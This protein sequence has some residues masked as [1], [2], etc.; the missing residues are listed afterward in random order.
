M[1]SAAQRMT[2]VV[3]QKRQRMAIAEILT[4]I[5]V[6]S[7]KQAACSELE[8]PLDDCSSAHGFRVFYDPDVRDLGDRL[9]PFSP[10]RLAFAARKGES[11]VVRLTR[12]A[13][14]GIA[15]EGARIDIDCLPWLSRFP[16]GSIQWNYI[17][18]DEFGNPL[19]ICI[20]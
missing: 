11:H 18:L 2:T 12:S 1:H 17:Q 6:I 19:G 4:A 8:N 3:Q 7:V 10:E 16:G 15:Q 9:P 13:Q 14:L 5:L 20:L